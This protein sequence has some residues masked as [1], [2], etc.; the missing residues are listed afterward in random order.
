MAQNSSIVPS[1]PA[2]AHRAKPLLRGW[3]HAVAAVLAVCLTVALGFATY[4]DPPR[5]LSLLVFGLSTV[6]LYTVSAVYH[7]GS[8]HGRRRVVLRALD[9]ANIFVLIAG[10]Y[11]PFCV[12][13]LTGWL[14]VG[15]LAAIWG[16][17]L[18]GGVGAVFT[19]R[20][21]RWATAGLYIG[22]GW[23]ALV[24]LPEL[25]RLWPWQPIAV[26]FAGGALY[27]VGAVVYGLRRPDP[28]PRVFGFHEIFH[29]FV[30]AGT[31]AFALAI[32][33]W[34]VPHPRA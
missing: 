21:P 32:W 7:I 24:S 9:H 10:T 3:F 34:V 15:I 26:L 33:L 29:L 1:K 28:L 13:V 12:N 31:A 8:W 6:V 23:V 25:L 22:M 16:L 2:S 19:L 17:A 18:V 4:E 20:F 27:T 11:T 14:R 30:I 5:F